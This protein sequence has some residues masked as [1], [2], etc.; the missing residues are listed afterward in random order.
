M[1][2]PRREESERPDAGPQARS[3]GGRPAE[4]LG[5][6]DR[7]RERTIAYLETKGGRLSARTTAA[8]L[9]VPDVLLLLIRLVLDRRTP[10]SSRALIGGALAYFL[11]PA[12]LAPEIVLGPLG[13]LD[14][15]VVASTVLAHV[16]GPELEPA[17]RRYWSGSG[18]SLAALTDLSRGAGELLGTDLA[19]R[20]QK[21]VERRLLNRRRGSRSASS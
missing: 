3:T 4:L 19:G 9:L 11:L 12:D 7:V 5:F 2:S 16:L 21:V 18:R 15:L 14:D 1:T 17:A 20:V 8:L 10:A 6:Y 13:W